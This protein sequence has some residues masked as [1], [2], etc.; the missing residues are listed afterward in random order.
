MTINRLMAAVLAGAVVAAAQPLTSDIAS[1]QSAECARLS[2][3]LSKARR[4][5][6]GKKNRNYRKWN[7]AARQQR[8][9]LSRAE[10]QARRSGCN[11]GIFSS[12]KQVCRG[13][14]K[15]IRRMQANLAKLERGRDRFDGNS[16]GNPRE[17]H[18]IRAKLRR[19]RCGQDNVRVARLS[20][21][22]TWRAA[23]QPDTQPR[24]RSRG[25]F[26]LLFDAEPRRVRR[27][28]IEPDYDDPRFN[29]RRDDPNSFNNRWDFEQGERRSRYSYSAP[30]FGGG[31]YRTLCVRTCDGYYFP[32]SFKTN[33]YNFA[34]DQA[35][36]AAMCPAADVRLYVHR[37]PGQESE[38][39]V[40]VDGEPYVEMTNAF[41]YREK[42]NPS[43]TCGRVTSALTTLSVRGDGTGL[44][45]IT[46]AGDEF[47]LEKPQD[48]MRKSLPIPEMKLP[49]DED[50]D[51]V[52]NVEGRFVATTAAR[53][54]RATG[55]PAEMAAGSKKRIRQVGTAFF[56]DQQ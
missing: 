32:I 40:S 26:G 7:K 3:Q 27:A 11:G 10:A 45:K 35:V 17:V 53:A 37:N 13:L 39:M 19:M 6:S 22:G 33:S 2:A 48:I 41:A 18:R 5:S 30:G 36:C 34:R 42:F 56:P 16:R 51:T 49:A 24:R 15:K 21:R 44:T 43:C 9:A 25:L 55:Q 20:E 8:A 1:A 23:S 38:E 52:M 54:A 12:P 50:P 29:D 31:N 28:R 4:S 14:N 46:L 47:N